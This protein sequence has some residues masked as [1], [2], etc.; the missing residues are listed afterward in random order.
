MTR[1]EILKSCHCAKHF[2]P[3]LAN[4]LR[5]SV[6]YLPFKRAAR[7]NDSIK[8]YHTE[9]NRRLRLSCVF[10]VFRW[11][12]WTTSPKKNH[13]RGIY[14][15][16]KR[17]EKSYSCSS[18]SDFRKSIDLEFED[19]FFDVRKSTVFLSTK[20]MDKKLDASSGIGCRFLDEE[21][22]KKTKCR[23]RET[24]EYTLE[25]KKRSFNGKPR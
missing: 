5:P 25:R 11:I 21:E 17:E 1:A 2:K 8:I 6:R 7:S 24:T 14:F 22:T 20:I 19:S 13:S 3:C 12:R 23:H 9:H 18:L 4:W 15:S 10:V 16:N